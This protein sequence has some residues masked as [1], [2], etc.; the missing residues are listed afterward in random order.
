MLSWIIIDVIA[1][2]DSPRIKIVSKIELPLSEVPW[3]S[4]A[5][6]GANDNGGSAALTLVR[7]CGWGAFEESALDEEIGPLWTLGMMLCSSARA[8]FPCR[9]GFTH[10]QNIHYNHT[11]NIK[12]CRLIISIHMPI[13]TQYSFYCLRCCIG[14]KFF[15]KEYFAH[16]YVEHESANTCSFKWHG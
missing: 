7:T 16:E 14:I 4:N 2:A 9:I 15:I 3:I 5:F 1:C 11:M 12:K 10:C 8:D 13:Y 6:E